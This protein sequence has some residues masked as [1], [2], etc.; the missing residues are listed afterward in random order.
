MQKVTGIVTFKPSVTSSAD[1]K[2]LGKFTLPTHSK[3][4]S[5]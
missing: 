2:Y 3:R 5:L 4:L 1:E